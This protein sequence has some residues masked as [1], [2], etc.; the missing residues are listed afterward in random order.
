MGALETPV[1]SRLWRQ[2]RNVSSRI[3]CNLDFCHLHLKAKL[4]GFYR[5]PT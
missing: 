3:F 1:H 5:K 4:T 2:K